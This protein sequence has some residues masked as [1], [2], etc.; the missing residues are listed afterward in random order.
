MD[1]AYPNFYGILPVVFFLAVPE[2]KSN[3]PELP[4]IHLF[5]ASRHQLK[6]LPKN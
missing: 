6:P 2:L 1:I 5:I 3:Y 4:E